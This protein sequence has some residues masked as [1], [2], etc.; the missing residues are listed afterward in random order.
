MEGPGPCNT[1]PTQELTWGLAPRE[2]STPSQEV[3][4]GPQADTVT[5]APPTAS[6]S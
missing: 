2:P 5:G 3:E 6:F 4:A 1:E